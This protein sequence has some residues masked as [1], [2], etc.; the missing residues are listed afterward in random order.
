MNSKLLAVVLAS[1]CT[2]VCAAAWAQSGDKPGKIVSTTIKTA[3][4]VEAVDP[5]TRELK[6]IDAS[7]QRFSVIA[8]D[9][10]RNFDQIKPRDRIVTEYMESVALFVAPHNSPLPMD[11]AGDAQVSVAPAGDKPGIEGVQ[12]QLLVATVRAIN[13][14]DRLATLEVGDG[15]MRTIKVGKNARLDLV[16]VGDQVRLRVTRA[17]AITVEAPPAA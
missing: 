15:Q 7:G 3:A 14:A 12:T 11:A 8:D 5:A 2:T 13:S 9:S 1:I 4:I 10:V 6:L 17:M 16:K